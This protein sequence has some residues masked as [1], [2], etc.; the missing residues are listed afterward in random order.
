MRNAIKGE[1]VRYRQKAA[2][3]SSAVIGA[4]D[5]HMYI[6]IERKIKKN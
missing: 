2:A 6:L 5:I 4:M 3:L 1:K